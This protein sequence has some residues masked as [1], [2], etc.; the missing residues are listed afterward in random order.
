[1]QTSTADP[2]R[3]DAPLLSI[4]VPTYNRAPRLRQC[5]AMLAERVGELRQPRPRVEVLVVDNASTDDTP[6]AAAAGGAAFD[7]FRFV[8]NDSNLGIDGNIHRCSQLARGEWVHFMSDDDLLLPGALQ[9]VV[10][11]IRVHPRA[12]FLFHNVLSFVDEL[13]PPAAWTPRLPLTQDLTCTDQNLLVEICGIW[14]TFLSSFVFRREAWNRSGKLERYVGTDIYLSY[15]LFDLLSGARESVVLA[16]PGVAAR[17]HFSGSY[18]IFYAF[19][20]QWPELLL[21]HAPAIGFDRRRMFG[22]LRRSIRVDLLWRVLTYRFKSGELREEDR[23][24]VAHSLRGW[25]RATALLWFA[26]HTPRPLLL[27]TGKAL[28]AARGLLHSR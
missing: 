16:Q 15:A 3:D 26:V 6:L 5:L 1:M 10:D 13:P 4:T 22:V 7:E 2:G 25:S 18:R 12:D 23:R 17:A 11:A 27:A 8:R 28:K 19:G 14:L 9:R 24:N 20:Y 21:V